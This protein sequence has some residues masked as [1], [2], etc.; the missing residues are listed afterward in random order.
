MKNVYVI[1]DL[2]DR[3]TEGLF[4]VE[5]HLMFLKS[6]RMNLLTPQVLPDPKKIANSL[7]KACYKDSA[8]LM[9]ASLVTH[10]RELELFSFSS[11]HILET[12]RKI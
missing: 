7:H 12:F 10:M 5:L 9:H 6:L 8:L 1:F 4:R 2:S 3:V 11:C